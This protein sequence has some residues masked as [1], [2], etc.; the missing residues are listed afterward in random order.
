MIVSYLILI[1]NYKPT[2]QGIENFISHKEEYSKNIYLI[3]KGKINK[4]TF[5]F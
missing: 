2:I 5:S 3:V 1:W 4:Q